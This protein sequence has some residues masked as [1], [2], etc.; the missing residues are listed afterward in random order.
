MAVIRID[1]AHEIGQT[2]G[3]VWT[4]L[5]ENGSTTLAKLAKELDRPRD[6]VM[7]SVGWLAREG[8]VEFEENS[9]KARLVRL[10]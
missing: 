2:A 7:Q 3:D 4:Y 6:I 9:R 10:S 1:G 8:K 5:E